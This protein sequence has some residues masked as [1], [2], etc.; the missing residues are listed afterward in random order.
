MKHLGQKSKYSV[1]YDP[2]ALDRELRSTNREKY[3]IKEDQLPFIGYDV[4][5]MYELS[6]LQPNGCPW[7][8]VGKLVY[9]YNSKYIVESK[10]LKLYLN[11]FNYETLSLDD[12]IFTVTTDL[13]RLLEVPV[14]F[15]VFTDEVSTSKGYTEY[16]FPI[17]ESSSDIVFDTFEESPDL[18][19]ETS[20]DQRLFFHSNLLRSNCKITHQPD[21]GDVYIF[22]YG[23]NL[24]TM[25]SLLKYIVS[26]R[27]EN[28]FHEEVVE[29]IYK[30]LWD[31]KG[32]VDLMVGAIY[33][34]RG[35][36]DICP[37]R[38]SSEKLYKYLEIE[39]IIK[40]DIL[41]VKNLRQ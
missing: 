9:P 37:C 27:G 18:L 10:S 4:W 14:E 23:E 38:V 36:I 33:T 16:T 35:G 40:S 19:K 39:N 28:H 3:D 34:R 41:T 7:S 32:V 17:Y 1:S 24:P 31:I 11:S 5:H 12:F 6:F 13:S 2:E 8:G 20:S 22:M 26:F 15:T 30:R 29:M 25:D 21:F